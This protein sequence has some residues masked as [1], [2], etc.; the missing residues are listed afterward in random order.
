M[1]DRGWYTIIRNV[2][3]AG[4][5]LTAAKALPTGWAI[6]PA[7]LARWCG[8]VSSSAMN[9]MQNHGKAARDRGPRIA[10]R[11]LADANIG[12]RWIESG[13]PGRPAT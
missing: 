3:E 6:A 7:K 8:W 9:A 2:I 4:G 1:I 13:T 11:R 5:V 10:I 12:C